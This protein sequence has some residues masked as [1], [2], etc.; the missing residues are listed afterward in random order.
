[1]QLTEK[2]LS[3]KDTLPSGQCFRFSECNG[4]WTVKAG[5]GENL[6]V[7]TVSQDDLSPITDDPFWSHFFD[8]ETDYECLKREFSKI[9]PLMA[10]ACEYAPGIRILNQDPWEALCSFVVSQNNNIKRIMGIVERMS[11]FYGKGGFPTV[12]SLVDAKEDD[13]RMLGLG[14][15]APYIVNTARA[16][17]DGL[18]NLDKLK[19]M[20][21]DAARG[22]LMKVKGIGPKVADCALL[23]GCHRLDCFPM[24][25]WMKRVMATCFSGQDKSIFG[26]CAGVAQQYLFHFAR[27]SGYFDDK[28]K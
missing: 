4:V 1:M 27:T 3:L 23:F 15:R 24:D 25:V 14:F 18:I 19:K 26:P 17:Y 2:E 8:L 5:V 10:Q 9:S 11:N 21:I 20:D 6:R 13:L 22:V 7:L 28:E 12:K 16:V